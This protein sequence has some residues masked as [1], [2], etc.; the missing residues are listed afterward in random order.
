[1]RDEADVRDVSEELTRGRPMASLASEC[2]GR[3][4][5]YATRSDQGV[6]ASVDEGGHIAAGRGG[7]DI[8]VTTEAPD[9][10]ACGAHEFGQSANEPAVVDQGFDARLRA[11]LK[12]IEVPAPKSRGRIV[13]VEH[14]EYAVAAEDARRLRQSKFRLGNVA[15]RRMEHDNIKRVV[16]Q[17]ERSC[18]ALDERQIPEVACKLS[19]FREKDRRW[20]DA[21][22]R[23]DTA[24][25]CQR[26]CYWPRAAA[27]LDDAGVRREVDGREVRVPHL[28][29][30][31][32]ARTQLQDVDEPIYDRRVGLGDGGVDV[33][34]AGF[35]N[36]WCHIE[37]WDALRN[38][39]KRDSF[40]VANQTRVIAAL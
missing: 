37:S 27:D 14:G 36:P 29:L 2:I 22:D 23:S 39:V 19:T 24:V 9:L 20:V 40:A 4:R 3:L 35:L 15:E 26:P 17:R 34:Q 10:E 21:D 33:R 25:S 13:T 18:V 38:R 11:R 16:L 12:R 32:I 1:L 28:A 8:A 30:L 31:R 5:R 6:G 7:L